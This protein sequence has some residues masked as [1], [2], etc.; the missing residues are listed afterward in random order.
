[1]KVILIQPN[2]A[3]AEL[4]EIENDLAGLQKAVGGLSQFL[5][6]TDTVHAYINEEGKLSGLLH[7]EI[8]TMLC[9]AFKVGLQPGDFIS[10]NMILLGA[11]GPDE[12]DIPTEFIAD[13]AVKGFKVAGQD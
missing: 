11:T 12:A 9:D 6:I 7:N 1:M 13:L 8:A 3:V 5:R 10:G 2:S 4:V